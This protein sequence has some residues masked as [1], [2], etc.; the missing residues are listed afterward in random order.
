MLDKAIKFAKKSH[1]GQK[2]KFSGEPFYNHVY[3]V[4]ETV[5][6][7]TDNEDLHAA[8]ILHDV[9]EDCNIQAEQLEYEF[10]LVVAAIVTDLTN[11]YT[12]K[13]YPNLSRKER[14]LQELIRIGKISWSAKLIK[15]A[16]RIDNVEDFKRNDE[17][18]EYYLKETR[19]L[20]EVLKGVNYTLEDRLRQ[21]VY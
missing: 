11:V 9:V 8:S 16:D 1:E 2:R 20:L 3:R 12:K 18:C 5:K 19:Q 4:H 14:K 21:L 6:T 13:N 17:D 7:Y 15:L 10:N